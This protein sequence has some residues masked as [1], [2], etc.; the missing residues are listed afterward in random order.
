MGTED[1]GSVVVGPPEGMVLLAPATVVVVVLVVAPAHVASPEQA[2]DVVY[3]PRAAPQGVPFLHAAGEPTI[4]ALTLPFLLSVQHTAAFGFPQMDA[5]SHRSTS[6]RQCFSG[7]RFMTPGRFNELFTHLLY[8]WCV[9]PGG[10]QPQVLSS[11][12]CAASI[13]ASSVHRASRQSARASEPRAW[14]RSAITIP[15]AGRQPAERFPDDLPK[16]PYRIPREGSTRT[17]AA[18]TAGRPTPETDRVASIFPEQVPW[19]ADRASGNRPEGT[20]GR[21]RRWGGGSDMERSALMEPG[22]IGRVALA[23]V[24]VCERERP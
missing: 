22:P 8:F 23:Y 13:D 18:L 9:W 4:D 1:G 7:S 19:R 10:V 15:A 16:V 2:L 17:N 12:A 3:R 6:A 21:P 5:L 20:L 24:T 11:N 14:S